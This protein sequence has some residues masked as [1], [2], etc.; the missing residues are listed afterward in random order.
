MVVQTLYCL[1]AEPWAMWHPRET[2]LFVVR[3][4]FRPSEFSIYT[5]FRHTP[6]KRRVVITEFLLTG[7]DEQFSTSIRNSHSLGVVM[8]SNDVDE[9]VSILT[10]LLIWRFALGIGIGADY[11]SSAVICSESVSR[12]FTFIC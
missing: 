3:L 4:A 7:H 10:W 11:P 5:I 1:L 6:K 8:C 12:P 9:S 2:L